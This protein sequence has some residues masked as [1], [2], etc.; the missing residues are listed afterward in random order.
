[1][2][3]VSFAFASMGIANQ[4]SLHGAEPNDVQSDE[5]GAGAPPTVPVIVAHRGASHDA[6]ENTIAAF[7]LAWQQNA[8]AIE[9]DFH[10]TADGQIVCL[11]DKNTRRTAPQQPDR[12]VA[13]ASLEELRSLDVGSWKSAQFAG[14][15]I[16]TLRE[17]LDTVPDDKQIYVEIKCGTEL[18]PEL[19]R[20]LESCRL[21]PEQIVL[22]CFNATVIAEARRTM[23]Q[24]EANWLTSY[25]LNPATQ[26]FSPTV[27]SILKTLQE[28][29]A[30]GFGTQANMQVV[31]GEFIRA[32]A[33][34]G[35]DVHVWTVDDPA[36]AREL[37]KRG[38]RSVTTNRPAEI[39]AALE[40]NPAS[41]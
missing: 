18:L 35:R 11:H 32:I 8:D 23:P 6:P 2:I 40:V 10:L 36:D 30:S 28:S 16:P 24:Y 5:H 7:E 12:K 31:T 9:G 3:A 17:V 14:E 33:E 39:R 38:V 15:A 22:I 1:M 19:K 21:R 27:S 26:Q 41:L 29:S 37:Q 13:E 20:Q 25:R 4:S 34:L